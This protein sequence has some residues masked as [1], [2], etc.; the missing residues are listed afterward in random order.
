MNN[1]KMKKAT[2]GQKTMADWRPIPSELLEQKET[3]DA[4]HNAINSLSA[5]YREVL[6]LRD[7]QRLDYQR[8]DC[9]SGDLGC[10]CLRRGCIGEVAVERQARARDRRLLD[11]RDKPIGKSDHGEKEGRMADH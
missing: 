11:Q 10:E 5:V 6:V 9:N 2:T 3:R 1:R 8:S 4:V 7:V